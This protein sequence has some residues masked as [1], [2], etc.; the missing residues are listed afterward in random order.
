MFGGKRYN[1]EIKKEK[2]KDDSVPF[3]CFALLNG[4]QIAKRTKVFEAA[5]NSYL[6]EI[7]M[8]MAS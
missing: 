8:V 6:Q 7:L 1:L 2:K 3:T 5:L 4:K